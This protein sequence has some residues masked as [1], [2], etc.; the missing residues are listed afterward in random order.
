MDLSITELQD[1][2][3]TLKR[4]YY[5]GVQ[6]IQFSD[7]RRIKRPGAEEFRKMIADLEDDIR[8]ANGGNTG[9][10]SLAQHRRGDGPSGPPRWYW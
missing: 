7:G 6:E 5:S 2:Y 4:A 3:A 9:S 1:L 8:Q 10:T